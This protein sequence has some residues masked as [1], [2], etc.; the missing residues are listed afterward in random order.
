MFDP[1]NYLL[2]ATSH[3]GETTTMHDPYAFEPLLTDYDLHL[4]S[5]GTHWKSYERLGAHERTVERREG[6]ELCRLG[7][8]R[9]ERR[10]SSAISTAGA[11]A[12]T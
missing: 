8:E 7:A 12:A 9:R 6:R 1:R 4:L 10:R 2:R 3:T 11:A 5:E